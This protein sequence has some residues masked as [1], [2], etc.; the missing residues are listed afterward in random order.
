MMR[1][2]EKSEAINSLLK[3]NKKKINDGK[4][5]YEYLC[6]ESVFEAI[7]TRKKMLILIDI[8]TTIL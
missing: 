8:E 7:S 3:I 4:L 6:F 5:F 1:S 2:N